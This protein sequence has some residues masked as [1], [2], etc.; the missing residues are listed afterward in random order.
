M[1]RHIVTHV[2]LAAAAALLALEVSADVLYKLV[3]KNGKV[4]YSEKKPEN[5]DGQVIRIDVNTEANTMPAPKASPTPTELSPQGAKGNRRPAARASMTPEEA[6]SKAEAACK[7]FATA[8]DNPGEDDV[9]WVAVGATQPGAPSP[10]PN[11]PSPPGVPDPN[12]VKPPPGFNPNAFGRRTGSRP[13][14]T[15]AFAAKL[16]GLEK[17]CNDAKEL[18]RATEAESK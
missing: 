3:D 9:T 2:V 6:R 7:A 5:F 1:K 15:D 16:A 18:V 17:S 13:V 12:Q 11:N 14:P 10:D 8:R 4:T